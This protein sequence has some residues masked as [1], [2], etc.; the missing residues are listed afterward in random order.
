MMV[1]CGFLRSCRVPHKA[2]GVLLGRTLSLQAD[3]DTPAVEEP[4]VV[5]V[6][7]DHGHTHEGSRK[8]VGAE[9]HGH[10]GTIA[11]G[12]ARARVIILGQ[13]KREVIIVRK[14]ATVVPL[15]VVVE[16]HRRK[17][18]HDVRFTFDRHPLPRNVGGAIEA[19]HGDQASLEGLADEGADLAHKLSHEGLSVLK[20]EA[21]LGDA[22]R[23]DIAKGA[24]AS[25]IQAS[26]AA[27]LASHRTD[28]IPRLVGWGEI[29]N[30]GHVTAALTLDGLGIGVDVQQL[31]IRL[32]GRPAP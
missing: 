15:G 5:G 13:T 4:Q 21:G 27:A 10:I 25:L 6:A 22:C 30:G 1:E 32:L 2:T 9:D 14:V 23:L 18:C 20:I 26:L 29:E 7:I 31:H 12:R 28:L 3:N 8:L 19:H 17:V 16:L 11:R 24:H